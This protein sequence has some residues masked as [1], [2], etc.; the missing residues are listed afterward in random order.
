MTGILLERALCAVVGLLLGLRRGTP[1]YGVALPA[2]GGV[3]GL[4]VLAFVPSR[5]TR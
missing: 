3:M 4:A 5:V 1:L 2:L